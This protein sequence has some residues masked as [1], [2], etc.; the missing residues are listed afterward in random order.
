MSNSSPHQ[1]WRVHINDSTSKLMWSVTPLHTK[2]REWLLTT[3]NLKWLLSTWKVKNDSSPQ[4]IFRVTPLCEVWLL[5]TWNVRNHS[6]PHQMW[7][8][9]PLQI[10]IEEWLLSTANLKSDSKCDELLLPTSNG[11][12]D[13]STSNVKSD[14]SLRQI[15]RVTSPQLRVTPLYGKCEEWLHS[16]SIVKSD[17][18]LRKIWRVTSLHV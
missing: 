17:S 6:A 10:K 3:A 16:T 18:S 9:I 4:Q 14:S 12:S 13:S 7:R 15:W 1:M 2:C 5:S 11:K 8:V